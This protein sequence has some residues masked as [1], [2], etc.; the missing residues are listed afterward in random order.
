M[1]LAPFEC[2][3]QMYKTSD[4]RESRETQSV[5]VWYLGNPTK[6]Y[7]LYN[8]RSKETGAKIVSDTVFFK[9]KYI[10]NPTVTHEGAVLQ[11]A[12]QLIM[13]LKVKLQTDMDKFLIDQLNKLKSVFK[14]T[15]E[16]FRQKKENPI[17]RRRP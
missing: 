13:T 1:L 8:I 9:L 3:V 6:H 12:Q 14:K 4:R 16:K 17:R 5:N 15:A 2:A 11:S 10:K 7:R